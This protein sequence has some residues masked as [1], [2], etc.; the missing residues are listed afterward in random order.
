MEKGKNK[1]SLQHKLRLPL[2]QDGRVRDEKE[3]A[4]E[5]GLKSLTGGRKLTKVKFRANTAENR[6]KYLK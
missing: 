6:K 5:K 3:K 1:G 4:Y 2:L